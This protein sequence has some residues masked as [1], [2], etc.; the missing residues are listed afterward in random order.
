MA[1]QEMSGKGQLTFRGPFE[2]PEETTCDQPM[3]AVQPA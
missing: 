1:F 3:I 2:L